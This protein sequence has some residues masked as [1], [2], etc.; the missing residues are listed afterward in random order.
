[1]SDV[2]E[3]CARFEVALRELA[4]W[5]CSGADNTDEVDD[6]VDDNNHADEC[7]RCF[8]VRALYPYSK[9]EESNK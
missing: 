4:Q 5:R 9:R 6:T 1:M 7:V 3:L 8:A 2:Y